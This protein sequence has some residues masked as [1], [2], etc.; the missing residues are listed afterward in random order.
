LVIC[1]TR[2]FPKGCGSTRRLIGYSRSFD[3]RR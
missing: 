2:A 3:A 1:M